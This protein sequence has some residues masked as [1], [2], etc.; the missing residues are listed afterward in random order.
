MIGAD[1]CRAAIVTGLVFAPNIFVLLTLVGLK[2]IFSTLFNPAEQAAIRMTV[3]AEE[4]HQANALSQLVL[5]S[6]KVIGPALGGLLVSLSGPRVA[7]AVDAATF[8]CSAA[9]LSGLGP[10]GTGS[11]TEAG[12]SDGGEPASSGFWQELREGIAY[13]GS[14]R[15]LIYSM[16]CFAAAIFLLLAFDSLSPLAFLELGVSRAE[17]GRAI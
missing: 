10:I 5:Q 16:A 12:S 11:T 13:I 3:P 7:F 14:R 1:L 6:T 15:A 17:F 8:L 9:I 2:T 4:L